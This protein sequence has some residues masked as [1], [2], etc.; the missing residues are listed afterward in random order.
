MHVRGPQRNAGTFIV[1]KAKAR[2]GGKGVK[3]SSDARSKRDAWKNQSKVIGKGAEAGTMRED[4]VDGAN[5]WIDSNNEER[6]ASWAAL[7]HSTGD[8]EGRVKEATKFEEVLIMGVELAK[9]R[10]RGGRNTE[11]LEAEPEV[12]M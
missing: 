10:D 4:G 3:D 7:A 9:S 6:S 12:V 1:A 11:R 8:S 2:E 5:K